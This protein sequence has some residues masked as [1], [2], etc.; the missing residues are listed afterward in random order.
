LQQWRDTV[1][2]DFVFSLKASQYITHK[3]KFNDAQATVSN[4]LER[5]NGLGEQLDIILF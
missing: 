4:L 1:P 3:K 2:D 5:V